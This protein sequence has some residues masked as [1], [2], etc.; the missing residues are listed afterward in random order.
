[1]MIDF[2]GALKL[3]VNDD[4]NIVSPSI[5]VWLFLDLV[6]LDTDSLNS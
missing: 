4:N 2:S 3:L 6:V 1:M 5:E